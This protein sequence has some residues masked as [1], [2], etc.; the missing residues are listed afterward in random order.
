MEMKDV[1]MGL[2]SGYLLSCK[3]VMYDHAAHLLGANHLD[4]AF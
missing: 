3:K 1:S 4:G 2:P